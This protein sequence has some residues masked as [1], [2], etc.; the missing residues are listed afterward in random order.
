MY[1]LINRN[2]IYIYIY[3]DNKH[4]NLNNKL[5][6]EFYFPEMPKCPMAKLLMNPFSMGTSK[7]TLGGKN[8]LILI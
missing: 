1:G 7:A 2:E 4:D 6:Y 8:N 5:F 3:I